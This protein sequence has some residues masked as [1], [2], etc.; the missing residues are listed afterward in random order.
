MLMPLPGLPMFPVPVNR[1]CRVNDEMV[2]AGAQQN[3]SIHWIL[4][5]CMSKLFQKI[6]DL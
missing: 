2:A 6:T 3:I 1:D 4:L 5:D